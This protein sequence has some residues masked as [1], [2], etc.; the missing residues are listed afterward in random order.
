[1]AVTRGCFGKVFA[2]ATGATS[3]VLRVANWE[4]EETVNIEDVS[5]IGDCTVTE[6]AGAK[7]TAG[8]I[9]AYWDV[10]AGNQA[11]FVVGDTIVLELYPGGNG[12][13]ATFYKTSTCLVTSL[14][15]SG[16]TEGAV[17]NNFG[18]TINGGFTT[19]TVP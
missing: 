6:V 3:Q 17:T 10:A 1:M 11:M 7:R 9:E 2:S 13:G 4:Y 14:S 19:T 8:N 18:F 12:S 5:E 16:G 15:R